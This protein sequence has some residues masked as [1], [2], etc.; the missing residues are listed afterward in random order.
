MFICLGWCISRKKCQLKRMERLILSAIK[1][2]DNIVHVSIP[3]DKYKSRHCYIIQNLVKNG[4][5]KPIKG[6]QGFLT[7]NGRFVDRTEGKEIAKN[8]NQIETTIS[9]VLTSEDLW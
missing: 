8:V 4:F 1:T 9:N 7:N 6:T 5:S 3:Y 2:S